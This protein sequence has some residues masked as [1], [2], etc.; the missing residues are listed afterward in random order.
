MSL[1]LI[2]LAC[3]HTS[4]L[5]H[6][7]YSAGNLSEA[8]KSGPGSH[9][10]IVA[11]L[12]DIVELDIATYEDAIANAKEIETGTQNQCFHGMWCLVNDNYIVNDKG[13]VKAVHL[14]LKVHPQD[15]DKYKL[16]VCAYPND[17]TL[18]LQAPSCAYEEY[19][20]FEDD[21]VELAQAT[22]YEECSSL[23]SLHK[24]TQI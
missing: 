19:K 6:C 1:S 24:S 21:Q 13:V 8:V 3:L 17:D 15:K 12:D 22:R 11:R 9:T 5:T 18:M 10:Y 2:H 20:D 7:R 16:A 23:H 4:H 14:R